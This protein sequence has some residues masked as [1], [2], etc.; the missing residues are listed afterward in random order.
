MHLT[1][2]FMQASYFHYYTVRNYDLNTTIGIHSQYL[3]LDVNLHLRAFMT[4]ATN[5]A[6]NS[7]GIRVIPIYFLIDF[8]MRVIH[9]ADRIPTVGD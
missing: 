4:Q 3:R 2:N 9:A 6:N 1:N 8:E 5:I 7:H